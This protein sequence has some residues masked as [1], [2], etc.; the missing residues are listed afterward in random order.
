M[1][2]YVC[3]CEE[4]EETLSW[5]SLEIKGHM[6]KFIHPSKMLTGFA[7]GVIAGAV[8]SRNF[9]FARNFWHWSWWVFGLLCLVVS[10]F[11]SRRVLFLLAL[12]GGILVLW[13][14][15][16][17]EA[18]E[19]SELSAWSGRT[20]QIVGTV[21]EDPDSNE[22]TTRLRLEKMRL[23]GKL[24]K[25][26]E[27]QG[28]VKLSGQSF[29]SMPKKQKI[30][31]GDKIQLVGKVNTGFG[32]FR[33]S[34]YRPKL[35]RIV[36][37]ND[38][39][40]QVRDY[41]SNRVKKWIPKTEVALGLGYLLGVKSSLPEKLDR[42]LKAIG[43]THIVV[44][45]GA[46][47]SILIN[48][49][50][51]LF[52]RISRRFGTMVS[53]GLVVF[54]VGMTGVTPSMSRAGIVSLLS[55]L[56]WYVGRKMQP[57]RLLILV[58]AM[59]LW[60]KP[61]YLIDLGWLLSFASF[62]GIMVL[63]P[64]VEEAFYAEKTPGIIAG[65]VLETVSASLLCTPILLFFFG[66]ISLISLA[67]NVLVLPTI[68]LVMILVFATGVVDLL[69]LG[70]AAELFGS[71]ASLVL[72]YHLWVIDFFGKR[73]EFLFEMKKEQL[74]VLLLYVPIVIWLGWSWKQKRLA[75]IKQNIYISCGDTTG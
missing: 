20:A 30:K 5:K 3:A 43:L 72:K 14:K 21:A 16:G 53:I 26:G 15:V 6:Q 29:V 54:Y 65:T 51:K 37:G 56:T 40:L 66:K 35:Q 28:G 42:T 19:K 48:I 50:R 31:R 73:K 46:N 52:G 68:S 41:F 8:L 18:V 74:L 61:D 39:F 11:Y 60:Y 1:N 64:L 57:V 47:L 4:N 9:A 36:K 32:I 49:A 13:Q 25:S 67:A 45:S 23:G 58:A 10:V 17:V 38:V 33:G 7:I 34:F 24:G 69:G 22:T 12:I 71:A 55:L 62:A 59:T 44:A 63:G 27:I 75:A 2:Y 70:L